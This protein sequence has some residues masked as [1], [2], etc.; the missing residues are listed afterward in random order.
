MAWPD[1]FY[2]QTPESPVVFSLRFVFSSDKAGQWL[3]RCEPIQECQQGRH[4]DCNTTL[5]RSPCFKAFQHTLG[6]WLSMS[7]LESVW[8]ASVVKNIWFS[9]S[10]PRSASKAASV[11]AIQLSASFTAFQHINLLFL[12]TMNKWMQSQST[13]MIQGLDCAC[14]HEKVILKRFLQIWSSTDAGFKSVSWSAVPVVGALPPAPVTDDDP[15]TLPLLNH[16]GKVRWNCTWSTWTE[17]LEILAD[18][19]RFADYNEDVSCQCFIGP[20]SFGS[21]FASTTFI[22]FSGT[23]TQ[24]NQ[25]DGEEVSK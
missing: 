2:L 25:D 22:S 6:P 11:T 24:G 17:L 13:I 7:S 19:D 3:I 15:T 5:W 4:I 21:L 14:F 10:Q 20:L 8:K 16:L 23:I 9:D 18:S 12:C 1:D